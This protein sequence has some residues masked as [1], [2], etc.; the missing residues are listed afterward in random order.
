MLSETETESQKWPYMLSYIAVNVGDVSNGWTTA[1][2]AT[3]LV[4]NATTSGLVQVR[5]LSNFQL[6]PAYT[7]QITHIQF[8]TLLYP[9]RLEGRL[10][11]ALLG[12]SHLITPS[13][14]SLIPHCRPPGHHRRHN[15]APSNK[16]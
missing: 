3:W 12:S 2:R 4:M 15:A 6:A 9:S 11:F 5:N 13:R 8:M 16:W 10:I 7:M 14:Y 1:E